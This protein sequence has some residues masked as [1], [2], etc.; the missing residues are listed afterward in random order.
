VCKPGGR[1]E[2]VAPA[3]EKRDYWEDTVIA[4]FGRPTNNIRMDE[5]DEVMTKYAVRST[6]RKA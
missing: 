2:Q 4:Q 6:L 3:I 5:S 1:I